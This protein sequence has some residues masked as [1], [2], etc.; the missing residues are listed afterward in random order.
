MS[1][2]HKEMYETRQAV[3]D[4]LSEARKWGI[5]LANREKAYR[6][7]LRQKI[8]EL[9]AGGTQISIVQDMAKGDEDVASL[10]LERDVAEVMYKTAYEAI[11]VY[12][13]E[14]DIIK[15]EIKREWGKSD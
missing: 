7:S 12:K 10:R 13:K 5:D 14:A 6:I 4:S 11:N 8:A 9:R 15:D 1:E 2:L 3:K